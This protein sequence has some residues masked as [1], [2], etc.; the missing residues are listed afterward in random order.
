MV[1]HIKRKEKHSIKIKHPYKIRG[2]HIKYSHFYKN[3]PNFLEVYQKKHI[4]L[5]QQPINKHLYVKDEIFR[6]SGADKQKSA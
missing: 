4:T 2:Q 6:S 1:T 5:H 3:T